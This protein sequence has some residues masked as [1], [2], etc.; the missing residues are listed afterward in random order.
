MNVPIPTSGVF[1]IKSLIR[2]NVVGQAPRICLIET[3]R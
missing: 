3:N 2:K 1:D